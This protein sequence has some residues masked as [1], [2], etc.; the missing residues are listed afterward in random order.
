M[1]DGTRPAAPPAS[2]F[3]AVI[4]GSGLNSKVAGA[5]VAAVAHA[6]ES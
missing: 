6:L 2:R 4:I 3:D 1:T 5:L